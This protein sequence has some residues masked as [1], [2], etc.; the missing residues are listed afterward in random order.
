[1]CANALM[2]TILAGIDAPRVRHPLGEAIPGSSTGL[3]P[4]EIV[5]RPIR[6]ARTIAGL[7]ATVGTTRVAEESRVAEDARLR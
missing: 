6:N 5:E 7:T 2:L 4:G 3:P 1:M